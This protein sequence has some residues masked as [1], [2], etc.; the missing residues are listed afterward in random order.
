[1]KR[2]GW[3][4]SALALG[5][6]VSAG[7]QT[8]S[9]APHSEPAQVAAYLK[10]LPAVSAPAHGEA[11]S[12][13]L[14]SAAIGCADHPQD[15]PINRN[16]YLWTY[17]K[18]ADLLEGYDRNR[19]FYGCGTWHDA[20][21]ATWMM[22]SILRQEPKIT[23]ASDIKDVL[24]THFRKSNTDGEVAFFTHEPGPA[25]GSEGSETP[26]FE[27]PF[28]YAWLLKLYGEAKSWNSADGRKLAVAL[29]PLAR[30][31]SDRTIFY[32]YDLKFPQ[33]TGVESNTAWSM[34]LALDGSNLAEN[35][36]L[37]TAIRD[38]ALRLFA[39]DKPCATN[40][41]PQN[42]DFVSSCLTEAA[43]MGRVMEQAAYVKWLDAYLPPVYAEAFQVYARPLD[44][45]HTST[46]GPDAELQQAAR[47]RLIA[48]EFQ[49]ATEMLTIA[50]ALPKDDARVAVLRRLASA[51]AAD[52][53]SR[54]GLAGFEGAHLA[55]VYA[56]LYENE[57]KGPA[58]LG[59]P[60]KPKGKSDAGAD[61]D[62]P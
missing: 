58:P 49:R 31:M 34:S 8:V 32:L 25:V 19:A 29:A 4:A 10:S 23:L 60:P 46:T 5:G 61:A 50:W 38:N 30:W 1:M 36:T 47:A 42:T 26:A 13:V 24:T 22:A 20:V 11:E 15:A 40:F 43:L 39:K 57:V 52:G 62:T 35:A 6:V 33:R 51:N 45:S 44:I 27:R 59:P 55:A 3:W 28:G 21:S 2:A 9:S 14:A 17:T 54:M 16:N 48:L 41:E 56:Q 53:Y 7:A 18:P 37:K 12:E